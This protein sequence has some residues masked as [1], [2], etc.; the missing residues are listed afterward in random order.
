MFKKVSDRK[1][2]KSHSAVA[3]R[4]RFKFRRGISDFGLIKRAE[5]VLSPKL[6]DLSGT[7]AVNVVFAKPVH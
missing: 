7:R 1:K 3:A 2:A 5:R 6:S 4:K